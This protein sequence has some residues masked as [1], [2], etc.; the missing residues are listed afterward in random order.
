MHLLVA[1][2]CYYGPDDHGNKLST[3]TAK[4]PLTEKRL[5]VDWET[6]ARMLKS[7]DFLHLYIEFQ[8]LFWDRKQSEPIPKY[9]TFKL[10]AG[11]LYCRSG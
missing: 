1:G 6:A 2:Q 10:P 11:I 8:T 4:L 3:T 9:T 5:G 7:T